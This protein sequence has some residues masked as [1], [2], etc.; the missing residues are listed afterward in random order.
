MN[1]FEKVQR[2]YN[3]GMY[4]VEQVR[5]FVQGGKITEEEFHEITGEH[6]NP[7]A[8]LLDEKPSTRRKKASK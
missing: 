7:V 5:V 8:E 2:Y 3:K 4:T 6:Y 1:W